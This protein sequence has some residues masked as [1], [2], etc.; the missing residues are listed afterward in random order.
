MATSTSL[1]NLAG[2]VGFTGHELVT[3]VGGGGKTTVL[4]ALGHQLQGR[5]I[6]TTTTK[7][8]RDQTCG[9]SVLFGPSDE[10]LR[11]ALSADVAVV[12]WGDERGQKAIGV[13]PGRCDE[14]FEFADYLLVE[15]DGAAGHPFKAPRPFEPVVPSRTTTMLACIGADSLGR[16]IADQCH[17]PL[18]V[19]AV[20]GCSPYERLTPE[21]A[22]RVLLDPRGS[23]KDCPPGARFVVVVN[24]V[25]ARSALLVGELIE[26]IGSRA[27]VVQIEFDGRAGGHEAATTFA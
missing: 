25:D 27:P 7:M 18:R 26:A 19:A 14:W 23:R 2:A 1:T 20:A 5:R 24:K 12:A 13:D 9:L 16:V 6:V 11:D 3:V 21:R 4:C 22:A 10:E 8:G 15:A 17:R